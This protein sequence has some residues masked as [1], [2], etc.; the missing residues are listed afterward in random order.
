MLN[1]K[2]TTTDAETIE[3][4]KRLK[5]ARAK[6][7]IGLRPA[8]QIIG[9]NYHSLWL[10]ENGRVKTKLHNATKILIN[11]FIAEVERG[12]YGEETDY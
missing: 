11:A 9:V 10:I 7:G 3:I 6:L 4:A 12:G 8:A 2:N 5:A 1:E